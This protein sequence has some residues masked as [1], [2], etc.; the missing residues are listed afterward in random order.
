MRM[1]PKDGNIRNG[2]TRLFYLTCW[3]SDGKCQPCSSWVFSAL[4]DSD[5]SWKQDRCLA[6]NCYQVTSCYSVVTTQRPHPPPLGFKGP[7][8]KTAKGKLPLELRRRKMAPYVTRQPQAEGTGLLVSPFQPNTVL[9]SMDCRLIS[10]YERWMCTPKFPQLK[11]Q[12]YP[13][14]SASLKSLFFTLIST[15]NSLPSPSSN[16]S[17]ELRDRA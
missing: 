1:F 10:Q 9:K 6:A 13:L 11:G 8:Q 7:L 17:Q 12:P 5:W 15:I 14:N 3:L 16:S 2:G 4:L